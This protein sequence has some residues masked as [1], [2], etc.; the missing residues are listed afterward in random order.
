MSKKVVKGIE[1]TIISL[2]D[3]LSHKYSWDKEYSSNIHYY[4]G[5]K[6][7]KA[8]K[9]NEKIIIPLSGYRDM[10]VSWGGYDPTHYHVIEKLSDIEKVFN[11]I[12]GG[13][14]LDLSLDGALNRAKSEGQT[15]KI[16]LKY[17]TIT[18]Y[19]KGT[20]HIEFTNLDLLKKF[21]L[22]GSQRKGWLPPSYGKATYK[23]MSREERAVIDDYEGQEEYNRV[24][25]NR[26]YY[27]VESSKLLELTA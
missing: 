1:E 26:D 19:K 12:D 10:D 17:F 6:T 20:A 23:D 13:V 15:K 7:N 2:F 22:F 21:N 14:T 24:M 5:W 16:Q 9:I 3:E 4:N 8:W 18:F 11:Y 27:I 25:N